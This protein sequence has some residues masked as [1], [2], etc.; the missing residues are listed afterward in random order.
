MGAGVTVVC[1]RGAGAGTPGG[2]APSSVGLGA[3]ADTGTTLTGVVSTAGFRSTLVAAGALP[4]TAVAAGPGTPRT[5]TALV[6]I[7]ITVEVTGAVSV[8]GALDT[9]ADVGVA[10][11][12]V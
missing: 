4:D 2:S 3:G 8:L 12:G 9:P 11:R 10:G 7:G 1:L 5:G 6:D